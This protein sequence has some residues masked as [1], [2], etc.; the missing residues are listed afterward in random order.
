[1]GALSEEERKDYLPEFLKTLLKA[2]VLNKGIIL[3]LSSWGCCAVMLPPGKKP[4]NPWTLFQAGL[5]AAVLQLKPTG[6]KVSESRSIVPTSLNRR[7]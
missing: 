7:G 6:I 3:E 1:M 5:P 4:D 2:S